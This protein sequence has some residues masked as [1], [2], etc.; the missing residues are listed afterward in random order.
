MITISSA[1]S[2][3]WRQP[4]AG[5]Q[6]HELHA[7]TGIVAVLELSGSRGTAESAM[8]RWRLEQD[9]TRTV[10]IWDAA[11]GELAADV[12]RA[13]LLG[14]RRLFTASGD[15]YAWEPASLWRNRWRFRRKGQIVMEMRRGRGLVRASAEIDIPDATTPDRD[16]DLLAIAARFLTLLDDRNNGAAAGAAVAGSLPPVS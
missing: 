3:S 10:R 13:S 1:T 12:S 14:Q 7:G 4:K 9:V 11:S 16:L 15:I 2:L 5:R 8:G 6:L